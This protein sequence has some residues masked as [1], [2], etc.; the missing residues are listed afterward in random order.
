MGSAM[1]SDLSWLW[2]MVEKVKDLRQYKVVD[3][4]ISHFPPPNRSFAATSHM[5]RQSDPRGDC[6]DPNLD[7]PAL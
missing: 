6:A 7:K 3:C 5:G 2:K 4:F 1:L